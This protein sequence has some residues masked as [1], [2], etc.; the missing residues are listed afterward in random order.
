MI[1]AGD[2]GGTKTLLGLFEP[3][4]PRPRAVDVREFSTQAFDSLLSIVDLFLRSSRE[5]ARVT[6]ASVGVAGPIRDQAAELTNVSWR[7]RAADLSA[8]LGGVPVRLLNDVEAMAHGL[9]AIAPDDIVVVQAGTPAP[10]GN[11][12]LITVGTG[13]GQALVHRVDGR[14]VPLASEGGHGDFAARTDRE[15]AVLRALRERFGRVDVERVVSGPGLANVARV[16][17]GGPCPEAPPDLD[18]A[19]E[20]A[21]VSQAALE[22]RCARCRESLDLVVEALGAVAGNLALTGLA[23]GGVYIGGGIPPRI[24]PALL[25]GPLLAAFRAKQPLDALMAAIPVSIITNLRA[26]LLGAAVAASEAGSE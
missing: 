16:L 5:T 12:A 18:P 9:S 19:G 6:A 25:G 14:P 22:G 7:V 2:V 21:H 4:H 17:H 23:T 3:D 10:D 24:L 13:L 26:G 8:R 20:P 15:I 11:L 1:L